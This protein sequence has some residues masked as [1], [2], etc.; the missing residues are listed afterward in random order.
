[1][2]WWVDRIWVGSDCGD[3]CGWCNEMDP[4]P[5]ACVPNPSGYVFLIFY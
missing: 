3:G 1:M 5:N 2:S 4:S